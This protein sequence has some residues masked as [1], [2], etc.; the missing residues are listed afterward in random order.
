MR[1]PVKRRPPL[2]TSGVGGRLKGARM[3]DRPLAHTVAT[4]SPSHGGAHDLM[5]MTG[6]RRG[7]SGRAAAG[8]AASTDHQ[9]L[10]D[11]DGWATTLGHEDYAV[12][13]VVNDV[14]ALAAAGVVPLSSV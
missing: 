6:M 3:C 7:Q 1:G 14:G 12:G 8:A 11:S 10:H 4:V 13:S 9:L 2:R 5:T